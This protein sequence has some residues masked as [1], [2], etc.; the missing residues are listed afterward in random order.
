MY[1]ETGRASGCIRI[2]EAAAHAGALL[3]MQDG[4]MWT[5]ASRDDEGL[6]PCGPGELPSALPLHGAH[7]PGCT[8][9][10]R[11]VRPCLVI[12]FALA[13]PALP[14]TASCWHSHLPVYHT[15]LRFASYAICDLLLTTGLVF[16]PLSS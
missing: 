7:P 5:Y 16:C 10:P 12:L 14:D 9:T 6:I 13:C 3:Q 15:A 8:A 2:A 4:S 11:S 1:A